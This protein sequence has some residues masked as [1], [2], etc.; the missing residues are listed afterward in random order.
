[1][2]FRSSTL[3]SSASVIFCCNEEMVSFVFSSRDSALSA[4]PSPTIAFEGAFARK[5][6]IGVQPVLK[7]LTNYI[8]M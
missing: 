4:H 8:I 2:N 3:A 7:N 6:S 1:V 5:K